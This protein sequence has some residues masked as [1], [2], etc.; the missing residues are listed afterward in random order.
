MKMRIGKLAFGMALT[1]CMMLGSQAANAYQMVLG[2]PTASYTARMSVT[3][4]DGGWNRTVNALVTHSAG[5]EKLEGKLDGED[6][7]VIIRPD[8][9]RHFIVSDH[10]P[11]IGISAP[12]DAGPLYVGSHNIHRLNPVRRHMATIGGEECRFYAV[13]GRNAAG[14][15][16][17]GNVCLTPDGVMVYA[18]GT[19]GYAQRTAEVTMLLSDLH[20]QPVEIAQFNMPRNVEVM[21]IEAELEATVRLLI[22]GLPE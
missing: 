4:T 21:E 7:L 17:V 19:A 5:L 1:A 12:A 9:N 11:G 18:K 6:Q 22:P 3:V 20:R 16:F 13:N 2:Y 15:S 14:G 8:I 10:L